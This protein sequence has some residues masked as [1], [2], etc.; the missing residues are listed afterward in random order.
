M[1]HLVRETDRCTV[2]LDTHGAQ[3][4]I[5]QRWQYVWTVRPPLTRWTLS[6]QQA[7]H[8]R[9]ERGIRGSWDNRARIRASG[10]SELARQLAGKNIPVRIDI[11]WVTSRPHWTVTVQKVPADAF[12]TSF[13][14]WDRRT[15][16]LDTN[17]LRW[18][19]AANGEPGMNQLPVSHEFSHAFGNVPQRGH[20]DEY[21]ADSPHNADSQSIVNV[22]NSLRPRHFDHVISELNQMAP[23][24]SFAVSSV[25]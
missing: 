12:V 21:R 18:R 25:R 23:D 20:G 19:N 1:G 22:G 16:T 8:R 15:I 4:L 3:I 11:K 13:V 9:A 5:I 7:F 24:T 2:D 14:V 10:T 6:E 17:D